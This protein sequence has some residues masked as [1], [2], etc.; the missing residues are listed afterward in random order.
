MRE[1]RKKLN[2]PRPK[3]HL[4]TARPKIRGKL[5]TVTKSASKPKPEED[6]KV[7]IEHAGSQKRRK[8]LKIC[9]ALA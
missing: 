9:A 5:E 3:V 8:F 6:R 7:W 1:R 2:T 4:N